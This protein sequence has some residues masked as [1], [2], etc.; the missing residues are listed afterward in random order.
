MPKPSLFGNQ[1]IKR[2][3][4]YHSWFYI[5]LLR[6]LSKLNCPDLLTLSSDRR[7]SI[8]LFC[9]PSLCPFPFLPLLLVRVG[10]HLE[11]ERIRTYTFSVLLTSQNRSDL[12]HQIHPF[13]GDVCV[14][15]RGAWSK[16]YWPQQTYSQWLHWAPERACAPSYLCLISVC[17]NCCCITEFSD[18]CM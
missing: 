10:G 17:S 4:L 8:T 11:P 7:L 6:L 15:S 3:T 1:A 9:C 14:E 18:T 12:C 13:G 5:S 16:A 2:G